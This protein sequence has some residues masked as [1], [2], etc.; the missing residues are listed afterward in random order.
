MDIEY[1]HMAALGVPSA[2]RADLSD[3]ASYAR[4]FERYD[5]EILPA[6]ASAVDKAGALISEMPSALMCME[7][8]HHSCHRSRLGTEIAR[9]TSLPMKELREM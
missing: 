1:F 4:L 3:Q 9:K 7:A 2:W 6:Q 5:N 8:D